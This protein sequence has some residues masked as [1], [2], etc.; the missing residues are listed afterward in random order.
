MKFLVIL[1]VLA[2]KVEL[3]LKLPRCLGQWSLLSRENLEQPSS[4]QVVL[5]EQEMKA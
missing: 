4:Q 2:L 1:Q 5:Q 3:F